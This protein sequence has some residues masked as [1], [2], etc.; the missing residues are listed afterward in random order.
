MELTGRVA[1]VTGASTGIGRAIAGALGRAGCRLGICARTAED[2]DRAA[3]E[4]RNVAPRVVAVPTDVSDEGAVARFAGRVHEELGPVEILVNNAGVGIFGHV[5]DVSVADFDR[6]F[7]ANVRGLFLCTRAFAPSMVERGDGVIVNIASLAGK[8]PFAEGAV[9][10]GSK[11]AVLG[12]SKS[13]MLDLREDGVRVLT[14]CP[15]SVSTPFFRKQD[16]LEPDPERI[17]DADDVAELVLFAIRASDRGTVSEV[18]FR[19]VRP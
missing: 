19:P 7:G 10:S 16:T 6:T 5:L 2:L 18:E 11:H 13:M 4:L 1:V 12:L 15:G 3:E 14:V 9:Y 8:N 17:L